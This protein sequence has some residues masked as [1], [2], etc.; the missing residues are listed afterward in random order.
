MGTYGSKSFFGK[1]GYGKWGVQGDGRGENNKRF[2][3][4]EAGEEL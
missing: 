4:C 2:V 3:G 1:R